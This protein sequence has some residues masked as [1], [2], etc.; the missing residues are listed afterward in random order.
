MLGG[1]APAVRLQ[2]VGV[3]KR[4]LGWN[5]IRDQRTILPGGEESPL[6]VERDWEAAA[7]NGGLLGQ[8]AAGEP[9]PQRHIGGVQPVVDAISQPV[10]GVLGVAGRAVGADSNL[11]VAAQVAIRVATQPQV[12]RFGHKHTAVERKET[13]VAYV[14]DGY[15][16]DIGTPAKY[17]QVHR[18]IM[19]GRYQAPPFAGSAHA[20]WV[21]PGARVEEGAELQGPCF[22]DDGAVI[23][24][25]ARVL[26][27]TVLG[28]G[29][30]VDEGAVV[31]G[32]IVWPNGWIGREA[33]VR[34]A[35]LGRNCHVGRNVSIERDAVLGDKTVLTDYS[36]L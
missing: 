23:K 20:A 2:Q 7:V 13:F 15:W 11:L 32:S 10:R 35:I 36:R 30:H 16:I 9:V 34:G 25:G 17:M 4:V 19:D 24:A 8:T 14:Y 33:V 12:R 1:T 29:T 27:Y 6:V 3:S 22:V 31:D 21:A 26:P 5:Q 28:R 18:D